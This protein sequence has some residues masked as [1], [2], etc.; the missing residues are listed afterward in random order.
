MVDPKSMGI[1]SYIFYFYVD[2]KIMA[3]RESFH[4]MFANFGWYF[5]FHYT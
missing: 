2:P 1:E 3:D 5:C 4:C